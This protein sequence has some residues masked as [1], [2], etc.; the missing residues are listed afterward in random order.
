MAT[1]EKRLVNGKISYRVK[2]R[3]KGQPTETATFERI[4]DAKNWA[5][6][7]ESKI[8]EGRYFSSQLAKKYTLS[9][10]IKRYIDTILIRKPK[11]L[12]DQ[13]QQLLVWD[14]RLGDYTLANVTPALLSEVRDEFLQEKTVR[15]GLRTPAT[16]NRYFGALSHLFTIAIKEWGWVHENPILKL[17]K[18]KEPRG[19]IRFL[20]EDERKR[21]IEACQKSKNEMLY[22]IVVICLSTGARKME[23]IGLKWEQIDFKRQVITLHETKNNERRVLPIA[24]L[25]LSLLERHF[26]K[27]N[28]D[29]PLVFPSLMFPQQPMEIRTSWKMVLKMADIK[30][31]RFHDLRHSA[32]SY[33]AMNGASLA[34]I[35]EIL[36]HKTLSMVKRYA[37]LSEAHTAKVVAAMNDKIFAEISQSGQH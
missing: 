20:A 35:S 12:R 7:T 31:F 21:L 17:S 9:D 15:K 27:R 19:R 34:E 32:A 4:T 13:K 26:K 33:L 22:P 10:A 1:I 5:R 6:D 28:P 18:L 2:I 23:I 37:H 14:K 3:L 36:G 25:A 11:S 30:D 16:V 8:A 24:G 29:S